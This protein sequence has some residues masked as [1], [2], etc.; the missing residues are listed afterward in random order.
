MYPAIGHA[1]DDMQSVSEATLPYPILPSAPPQLMATPKSSAMSLYPSLDFMGL[2]L[3]E[4]LV[5]Q[6]VPDYRVAVPSS[7][8]NT[9]IP[10]GI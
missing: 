9:K 3:S 6:N 1:H 7:V 8:S 4:E 5:A 2:E 10:S